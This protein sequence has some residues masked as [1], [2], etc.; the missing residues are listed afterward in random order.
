M[1]ETVEFPSNGNTC[2]G[3]LAVPDRTGP[4]LVVIQEW[5]GL[6][7]H[8]KDVCDRFAREGFVALAPDLYHGKSAGLDEPDEAGKHLMAMEIDQ[9]LKDMSGAYE[10][11]RDRPIVEP[12]KVGTVGFCMGGNL[13]LLL[14]SEKPLDAAVAFYPYPRTELHCETVR[15][16]VQLHIAEH[17]QAPS[18]EMAEQIVKQVQGVGRHG[19][20]HVYPG[21][22]HAF[23][24]DERPETY[25]AEAAKQAWDRTLAFLRE[26][27]A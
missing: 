24:N 8:I 22:D 2:M 11:L 20:L 19:E 4:G 25:K 18:P 5:W 15:G 14:A 17:D 23:F 9:A 26:Y 10:Y 6:V 3:Y 21:T 16:A 1:G 7:D 12:K 27:L 13:A